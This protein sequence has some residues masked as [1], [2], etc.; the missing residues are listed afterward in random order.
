MLPNP[1]PRIHLLRP[2]TSS[3]QT[4]MTQTHP[5]QDQPP[6]ALPQ[7]DQPPDPIPP[8]PEPTPDLV[9][10]Q[11]PFWLAW[12]EFLNRFNWQQGE[13]ITAIGPTGW[14]KSTLIN[15]ILYNRDYVV[16]LGVKKEDDTLEELV[17]SGYELQRKKF[18]PETAD[19]IVVW[20]KIE[21]EGDANQRR[22]FADVLWSVYEMGGWCVDMDEA[23]Y[24][25]RDLHLERDLNRLWMNGRSSHISV[26]AGTQRP[27][28]LPLYGYDQPTHYFFWRMRLNKDARRVAEL[29][30]IPIMEMLGI[31]RRLPKYYCLY[32]NKETD[33]MYIT[34]PER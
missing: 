4:D 22:I 21:R 6:S 1:K 30:G 9:P 28:F 26:V 10:E 27:A 13:H 14:G 34:K 33:E 18:R 19:K 24:L 32:F 5:S 23:V 2:H 31:I 11:H 7:T 25:A 8:T 20:P 3:R 29:G 16:A 17:N 15:R 12:P